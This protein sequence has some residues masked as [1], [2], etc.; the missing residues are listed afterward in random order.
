MKKMVFPARNTIQKLFQPRCHILHF[1]QHCCWADDAN[2]TA[3]GKDPTEERRAW[4]DL[5]C[6]TEMLFIY[7]FRLHIFTE[8]VDHAAHDLIIAQQLYGT[9][10]VRVHPKH[11]LDVLRRI[12]IRRLHGREVEGSMA[13]IRSTRNCASLPCFS[14]QP[15]A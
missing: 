6:G 15:T 8:A 4:R 13:V 5:D 12:K 9:E 11:L 14:D 10:V 3:K 7:S 2:L 1:L